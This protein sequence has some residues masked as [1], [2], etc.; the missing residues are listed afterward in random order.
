MSE[1]EK[2]KKT[3]PILQCS[4]P[5]DGIGVPKELGGKP[6]LIGVF[7]RLLKPT[8]LPQFFIFNRWINGEGEYSQ[9]ITILD[10]ELKE[11]SKLPEQKFSLKSRVD[12]ADLASAFV[13]LNFNKSGVYWVK[14]DLNEKTVLSYPF[15][16]F[17]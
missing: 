2:I 8:T 13:N 12:S 7:S 11:F 5:C 14:I 17:G 1:K 6:V 4:I 15:P 9:T 3:T 10:P 16:V